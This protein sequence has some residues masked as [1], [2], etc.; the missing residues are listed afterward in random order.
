MAMNNT[1]VIK[2]ANISD[3]DAFYDLLS[4]TLRQGY[5]LYSPISV[6]FTLEE[7]LPKNDLK[8]Y[9][10]EGKRILFLASVDNKTVG[11]LLTF[12]ARAGVA[13]A[14]WLAVQK[15]YQKRGVGSSLLDMWQKEALKDGAQILHLWTTKNDLDFYKNNG[16]TVG[17]EFPDSWFGVDHY[18]I[19]KALRKSDE[20]VFL[21]EY[22]RKKK[23]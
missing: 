20:K 19:Y 7:D 9:V 4:K 22:L 8:K 18:L 14:Q 10:K 6:E 15:H 3:F 21:K 16:F 13:F 1:V 2:K 12:K 23:T 5:F 17:G 11:Y